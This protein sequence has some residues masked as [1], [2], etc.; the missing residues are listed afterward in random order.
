MTE[1][2]MEHLMA[3]LCFGDKNG[4]PDVMCYEDQFIGGLYKFQ[5]LFNDDV[6]SRAS[7][8]AT[9]LTML[10]SLHRQSSI[11]IY[12]GEGSIEKGLLARKS[13]LNA[14]AAISGRTLLR[15]AKEVLCKCK[16]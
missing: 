11:N 12:V 8:G 5:R 2:I 15:L 16:R 13:L 14:T 9:V 7:N 1:T 10:P 4:D 6:D 3:K